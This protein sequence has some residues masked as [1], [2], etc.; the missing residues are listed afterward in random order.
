MFKLYEAYATTR[1]C[2]AL[3]IEYDTEKA[4]EDV[5]NIIF[6]ERV[7]QVAN[8]YFDWY[9]PDTTYKDDV[10]AFHNAFV[11]FMEN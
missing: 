9:D 3:A 11:E 10:L 1:R 5:Y 7:S 4:W 2:V 6:S 8:Q